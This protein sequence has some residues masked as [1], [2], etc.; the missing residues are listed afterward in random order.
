MSDDTGKK[1]SIPKTRKFPIVL[2]IV[3]TVFLYILSA[4]GSGVI[5]LNLVE[6][7]F[8][9]SLFLILMAVF[10]D[11]VPVLINALLKKLHK[12]DTE[13]PVAETA[14]IAPASSDGLIE[15]RKETVS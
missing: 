8:T 14:E 4:D 2:G 15:I 1:F 7:I 10:K 3:A 5:I 11:I 13:E 6:L 12:A 9:I